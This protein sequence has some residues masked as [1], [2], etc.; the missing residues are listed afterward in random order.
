MARRSAGTNDF[1]SDDVAEPTAEPGEATQPSDVLAAL[2]RIEG[3]RETTVHPMLTDTFL[4][5]RISEC[6][7]TIDGDSEVSRKH[8]RII[9]HSFHFLIEDLKSAN[10]VLING[11]PLQGPT[12]LK[13]GDQVQIGSHLFRFKRRASD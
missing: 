12:E 7:L 3:G 5:G 13:V 6:N 1:A 8:A 10:G 11:K 2:V 9:R 4:I